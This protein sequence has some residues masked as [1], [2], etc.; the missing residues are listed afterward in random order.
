MKLRGEWLVLAERVIDDAISGNVTLVSCIQQ[1]AAA[2]FPAQHHGFGV[3]ARFCCVGEP[4]DKPIPV[5]LRLVRRSATDAEEVVTD[6]NI[7]W[8]AGTRR[9]QVA[10]NFQV[11]RL[12]R[13][14]I[15]EFRIDHRVGKGAWHS[16]PTCSIDVL[17]FEM[18]PAQREA[19]QA[20]LAALGL[21]PDALR[22]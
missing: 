16:G 10:T 21:P 18:T 12:R 22:S 9:G 20:Q 2:D 15:V 11:L 8:Q 5:S 1:V 6:W 17:H 4:P 7:T 3:A 13:P 19:L 14:E